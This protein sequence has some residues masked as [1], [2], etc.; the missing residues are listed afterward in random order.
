MFIS[1]SVWTLSQ[2]LFAGV[3]ILVITSARLG[4]YIFIGLKYIA[5][6]TV[7]MTRVTRLNYIY[8]CPHA[9]SSMLCQLVQYL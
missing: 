6:N 2:E 4:A 1:R 5:F 8:A 7:L 9:Q 3:N